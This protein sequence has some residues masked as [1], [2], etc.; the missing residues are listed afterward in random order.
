MYVYCEV[1]TFGK[2]KNKT[3]R[4]QILFNEKK[5]EEGYDVAVLSLLYTS[6]NTRT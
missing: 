1:V 4:V 3:K 6:T 5:S 2:F